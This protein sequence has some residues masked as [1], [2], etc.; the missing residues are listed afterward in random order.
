[1]L[2]RT[3]VLLA[4][5]IAIFGATASPAYA[6]A[7]YAEGAGLFLNVSPLE[8]RQ[9]RSDHA[10]VLGGVGVR[11][12]S[13]LDVSVR[14][15]RFSDVPHGNPLPITYVGYTYVEGTVSRVFPGADPDVGT[16]VRASPNLVV[17]DRSFPVS[18]LPN[19]V[20]FREGRR[21]SETGLGVDAHR[22][23]RRKLGPRIDLF[24]MAGARIDYQRRRDSQ[25]Q[26]SDGQVGTMHGGSSFLPAFSAAAPLSI[27]LD[28]RRRLVIEPTVR[29]H[30]GYYFLPAP[31][32]GLAVNLNL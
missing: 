9:L 7:L 31:Q 21:I 4:V 24:L 28:D 26:H 18:D 25:M 15:G 20:T 12:T 5:A 17:V 6:Q 19:P 23:W 14:A 8:Q 16:M 1:M 29:I 3:T 22:Y 30:P 32:A 13:D 11:L 10:F 27:G 2:P